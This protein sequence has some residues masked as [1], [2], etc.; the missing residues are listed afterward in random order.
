[1]YLFWCLVGAAAAAGALTAAILLG[2]AA[3][4]AGLGW[5]LLPLGLVQQL[6]LLLLLN[7]ADATCQCCLALLP[8]VAGTAVMVFTLVITAVFA[9]LLLLSY[10]AD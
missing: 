8:L 10:A 6:L 7:V 5:E 9:A 4:A 3:A 1:L 2:S